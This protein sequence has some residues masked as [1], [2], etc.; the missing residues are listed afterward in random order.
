MTLNGCVR[1][2]S[3]LNKGSSANRVVI[4]GFRIGGGLDELRFLLW[5]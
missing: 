2:G 1:L 4:Q 3:V 5:T